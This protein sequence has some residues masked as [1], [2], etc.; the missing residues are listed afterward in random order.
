MLNFMIYNIVVYSV[1]S[2]IDFLCLKLGIYQPISLDNFT[3]TTIYILVF[4][5]FVSI[6]IGYF[7]MR[8]IKRNFLL[9]R[10]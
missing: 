5:T 10:K 6:I 4:N 9:D 8:Y 2:L 1:Y 7:I 3:D